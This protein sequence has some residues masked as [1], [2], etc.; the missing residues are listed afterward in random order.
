MRKPKFKITLKT[1]DNPDGFTFEIFRYRE[2]AR[3]IKLCFFS[4]LAYTEDDIT[5]LK[6][7]KI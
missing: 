5:E 3:E 4:E 2:L 6:M 1:T 7:E